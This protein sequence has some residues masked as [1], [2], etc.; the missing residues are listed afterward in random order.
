MAVVCA[1]GNSIILDSV[2]CTALRIESSTVH[3]SFDCCCVL[4]DLNDL[5]PIMKRHCFQ[6]TIH[7]MIVVRTILFRG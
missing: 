6:S 4:V 7:S 1:A 3:K 5:F 2:A